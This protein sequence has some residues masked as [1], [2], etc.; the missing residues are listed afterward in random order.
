MSIYN[1]KSTTVDK[2]WRV[3][4]F[5]NDLEVESSYLSSE[6]ECECPAGS[7]PTCRHRQMIPIML[8]NDL[9]DTAGFYDFDRR[10][11]LLPMCTPD[12]EP[13]IPSVQVIG[14]DN[15]ADLHNAI[16]EAV[17]E[18]KLSG[19]Q[20]EQILMGFHNEADPR[21]GPYSPQPSDQPLDHPSL[22]RI[23]RRL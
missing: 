21:H 20:E 22:P 12:P 1:I 2:T 18:P 7:R 19:L 14:L 17:G 8:D 11:V 5:T 3:T 15:P 9:V 13:N 23:T 10:Q 6:T 16:A 4:K